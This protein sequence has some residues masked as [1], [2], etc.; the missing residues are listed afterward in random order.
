MVRKLRI[1]CVTHIA[2]S[3]AA[4]VGAGLAQLPCSDSVPLIS[5]QTSMVKFIA[6]VYGRNL[7]QAAVLARTITLTATLLGRTVSRVVVDWIPEYGNTINALT[8]VG[9]TEVIGWMAH[10]L[11]A[12]MERGTED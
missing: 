3:A 8:A 5:I 4:G 11:F 12:E 2:S 1:H 10:S 6:G 7:T 9:I